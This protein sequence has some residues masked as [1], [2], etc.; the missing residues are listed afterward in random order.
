MIPIRLKLEI[1]STCNLSCIECQYNLMNRPRLFMDFADIR[2]IV[3]KVQPSRLNLSGFGEQLLHPQFSEIILWL[4]EQDTRV[5]FFTNGM[6]LDG[7]VAEAIVAA[8][9]ELVICSLDAGTAETYR[10]IRL[11]GDFHRVL[12]NLK[13][14]LNLKK[15]AGAA[16]PKIMTNFVICRENVGDIVPYLRLC[17]E[18]LHGLVPHFEL[19]DPTGFNDD[20]SLWPQG[21][22]AKEIRNAIALAADMGFSDTVE[23]LAQLLVHAEQ[24]TCITGEAPCHYAGRNLTVL[25][26]GRVVPCQFY[27]DA[28]RVFG[29]ILHQPLDE[30][31]YDSEY[32]SFRNTIGRSRRGVPFCEECRFRCCGACGLIGVESLREARS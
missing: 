6:C 31:W 24:Q 9:V 5:R 25:A 27:Y 19:F 29:N 20:N 7:H 14:L 8:E 26:D 12:G 30:I 11:G 21:G 16:A 13:G 22:A 18:E 17:G 2:N 32:T 3:G 4:G 10:C 23:T 28:Q 15:R 1:S